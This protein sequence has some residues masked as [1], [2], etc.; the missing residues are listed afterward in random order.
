V[1]TSLLLFRV[2]GIDVKVHWSFLLALIWG[3]FLFRGTSAGPIGGA[4]YGVLVVLLLFLCVT[5]H[6]FGHALVAQYFNIKVSNITLLPIGGV[7]NLQ[8][9]PDK[10]MQELLITLAGPLV[11]FVIA[12]IL[13]PIMLF[14]LTV[15]LG[16]FPSDMRLLMRAMGEPG[17]TNLVTYLFGANLALGIFN[18]LPAFPMD[19]GRILRA[20]LA[21][22]MPYVRATQTAVLVGR[23]FA[24]LLA[25]WG[26][27]SGNI[28]MLL[29]A[30]FVY[31]GGGAE[32]EAV[33]SKAVLRH[34]TA[35]QA[36]TH[37]AVNLYSSERL[38][39]AVELIMNTYQ[40]DY[41]V[42]DLTSKF[43]GVLTR[44]RLIQALQAQGPDGRVID[45]MMPAENVPV[46]APSMNLADVWELMATSGSRVVAVKNGQDF[47]GL[48]TLEDINEV[49]QVM[50]A[51]MSRTGQPL[52]PS[53]MT[54]T[55]SGEAP[56]HTA[57]DA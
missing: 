5:L 38:N 7:A 31:V 11:N 19:G 51:S 22:T 49:F 4:L 52:P 55:P 1:G 20:L 28:S 21:M 54:A 45:V 30:F 17:L 43:I 10:P 16:R 41:P 2:R 35:A 48:I 42:L 6:E 18:L 33:E 23:L 26:L 50:G 14:L 9:M 8:R 53:S 34:F 57:A 32:R 37:T 12:L 56:G 13:L 25:I 15:E 40:A 47:M 46:V 24:G 29:I 36:L 44:P 27:M 3:A 39:R